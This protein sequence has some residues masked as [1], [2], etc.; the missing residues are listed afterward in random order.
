MKLNAVKFMANQG[1]HG[2]SH[3][4]AFFTEDKQF[5]GKCHRH[6]IVNEYGP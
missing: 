4:C 2:M 1:F 3:K 6:E 5:H